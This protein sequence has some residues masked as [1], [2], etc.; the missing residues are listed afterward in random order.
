MINE[1]LLIDPLIRD[2]EALKHRDAILDKHEIA[3][4]TKAILINYVE[5]NDSFIIAHYEKAGE[6]G[7]LLVSFYRIFSSDTMCDSDLLINC[8]CLAICNCDSNHTIKHAC[9]NIYFNYPRHSL[10]LDTE[11]LKSSDGK[12]FTQVITKEDISCESKKGHWFNL[13]ARGIF[14]N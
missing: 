7:E 8:N 10:F 3:K 11:F 2:K 14:T 5:S 6:E 13:Y 12:K 9:L 1:F 4:G